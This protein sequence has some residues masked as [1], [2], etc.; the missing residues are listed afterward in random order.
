MRIEID[1]S[2]L[3]FFLYFILDIFREF[4]QYRVIPCQIVQIIPAVYSTLLP[5]HWCEGVSTE[6]PNT[7][8][9]DLL[10][11]RMILQAPDGL[12]KIS[13]NKRMTWHSDICKSGRAFQNHTRE[14][15]QE[16]WM[17]AVE[18][19]GFSPTRSTQGVVGAEQRTEFEQVR[20]FHALQV[21]GRP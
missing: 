5:P 20:Q 2:A 15:L 19:V 7:H 18:R 11:L 3:E 13:Q 8:F 17:Q 9:W 14:V 4:I 10:R 6:L 21:S 1:I 12:N 16:G